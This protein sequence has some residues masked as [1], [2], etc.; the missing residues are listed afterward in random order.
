MESLAPPRGGKVPLSSNQ[1]TTAVSPFWE[2]SNMR[3][4]SRRSLSGV[5]GF[6][7]IVPVTAL[8]DD[9]QEEGNGLTISTLSG[10]ADRVSG[11]D[12]LVE[13]T[14]QRGDHLT[15]RLNGH[16]VSSAFHPGSAPNSLLGLVTGLVLGRNTLTVE[17]RRARRT[18]HLTNRKL[19]PSRPDHARP[20]D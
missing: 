6:L 15:I 18:L 9:G 20:S 4:R 12:A 2:G 1:T 7:L 13:I 16:D 10:A 19:P 8:A 14:L 11:G 3:A 17:G 5:V